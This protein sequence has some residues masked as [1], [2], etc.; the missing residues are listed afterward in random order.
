MSSCLIREV[1]KDR[2][3][4]KSYLQA[5]IDSIY[6][7]ETETFLNE[8]DEEGYKKFLQ[9]CVKII[10]DRKNYATSK[11]G[12]IYRLLLCQYCK[13]ESMTRMISG[14]DCFELYN[15]SFNKAGVTTEQLYKLIFEKEFLLEGSL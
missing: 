5:I 1:L 11:V 14:N 9:H 12:D 15:E 6:G 10:R 13:R 3:R 4:R 2:N 8:M 7:K